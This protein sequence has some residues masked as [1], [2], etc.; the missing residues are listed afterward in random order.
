M[1][2]SDKSTINKKFT[3][4]IYEIIFLNNKS[5]D[6]NYCSNIKKLKK[7]FKGVIKEKKSKFIKKGGIYQKLIYE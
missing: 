1:D 3:P 5:I 6:D 2:Y 7:Y 4:F